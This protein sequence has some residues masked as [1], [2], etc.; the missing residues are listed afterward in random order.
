M[1]VTN[2][3]DESGGLVGRFAVTSTQE[4]KDSLLNSTTVDAETWLRL[5]PTFSRYGYGYRWEGSRTAQFGITVLLVLV[6]LAAAHSLFVLYKI[7]IAGAGLVEYMCLR[8]GC[9]DV[10]PSRRYPRNNP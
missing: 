4:G 3:T 6:A 8:Q 10:E 5:D 2:K 9:D 7:S 1:F